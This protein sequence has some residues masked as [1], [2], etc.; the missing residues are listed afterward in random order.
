MDRR[1]AAAGHVDGAAF[2]DLKQAYNFHRRV[3]HRLQMIDDRQTH[4]LPENE[5]DL[6]TD[7]RFLGYSSVADFTEELLG[8][9]NASSTTTRR[10]SR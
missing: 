1:L 2:S 4:E 9:S 10:C 5:E 8:I 7:I 3:E 6:G